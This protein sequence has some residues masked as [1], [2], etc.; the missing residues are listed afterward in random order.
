MANT[1]NSTR[2][3]TLIIIIVLMLC[4]GVGVGIYSFSSGNKNNK[5]VSP[6]SGVPNNIYVTPGAKSSEKYAKL[7]QAA[8]TLGTKKADAQGKTFIPTI[9]GN[10]PD[11]ENNF[12]NQLSNILKDAKNPDDFG[13]LSKQLASLLADFNKQGH[14]IDNL[15][16]LIRELQQRGYNIDDLMALIKKLMGEGYNTDEL[17][18]LLKNLQNQ[19][20]NINDLE[21]MLRRLLKEGYDPDLINKIL[22]QLLKDRLK[23][24]ED[25][26]KKLQNAGYNVNNITVL[27]QQIDNPDLSKLLEQL[28]NQGFRMNSLE[29]LLKQLRDKGYNIFDWNM[30]LQQLQKDGYD[31]NELQKLLDK[32]K[33]MGVDINDLKSLLDAMAKKLANNTEQLRSLQDLLK[34]LQ[35]M[36]ADIDQL[37]KLLAELQKQGYSQEDLEKLIAELLKKGMH[38]NDIYKELQKKLTNP[39]NSDNLLKNQ[40]HDVFNTPPKTNEG[41]Q[42]PD[43]HKE[44]ANLIKHQQDTAI[45]AEHTKKLAEENFTKNKQKLLN[46]EAQQKILN[47]ILANMRA[48]SEAASSAWNNIPQQNFIQGEFAAG[49]ET[50]KNTTQPTNSTSRSQLNNSTENNNTIIKAGTILFAVLETAVNSDEPGPILARIVQPPLKNT[51]IIGTVQAA[52]NKDSETLSLT[53]NTANIPDRIRSYGISALAIDPNTARTAIASEVDHHYLLRWGAIFAATFLQGYSKAVAQSATTVDSVSNGA[54]TNT[55]TKQSPLSPKQQVF[56]GIGDMASAWGQGISQLSNRPATIKIHAGVSVGILFTSDFTIPS[57]DELPTPESQPSLQQPATGQH[58][59]SSTPNQQLST[60]TAGQPSAT[61]VA[62]AL[63]PGQTQPSQNSSTVNNN[64][65]K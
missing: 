35:S 7:Q 31:V 55:V 16:R 57:S 36:G 2:T 26:I 47:E 42:P 39:Q 65:N 15:L 4:V 40:L 13:R 61:P 41:N 5:M 18:K 28:A 45:A 46:N 63:P 21:N 62:T 60:V 23:A 51:K 64:N 20:Y 24:L 25:A 50:D 43:L 48:E 22:E 52:T 11:E 44:Y 53:F 37:K 59:T 14:E 8:N 56:Q 38:P 29:D 9:I 6:T 17:L 34:K 30:M 12:N 19:G 1:E 10:K 49:K 33:A 27:K 58:L 54:Q 32:L 3:R